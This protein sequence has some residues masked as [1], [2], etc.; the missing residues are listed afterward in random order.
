[1]NPRDP[2][3]HE[4]ENGAARAAGART[5]HDEIKPK[6]AGFNDLLKSRGSGFAAISIGQM[7]PANTRHFSEIEREKG[8]S[9]GTPWFVGLRHAKLPT[10]IVSEWALLYRLL[11][12]FLRWQAM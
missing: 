10:V 6:S 8:A 1:V 12:R 2:W 9:F 7:G 5:L 3:R 11:D 4:Q